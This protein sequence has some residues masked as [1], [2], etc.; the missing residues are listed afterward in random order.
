MTQVAD[1]R[2]PADLPVLRALLAEY[3]NWL[4]ERA[5]AV[6]GEEVD[7]GRLIEFAVSEVEHFQPPA[8]RMLLVRHGDEPAGLACMRGAGHGTAE[9]R[10]VFVRPAFRRAGLARRMVEDLAET[11]RAAGYD[12][13][14]LDTPAF[15]T[16]AQALYEASGFRKFAPD[17]AA[18]TK[19]FFGGTLV[20]ME[21]RLHST[22]EPTHPS[23]TP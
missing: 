21:R 2:I 16:Q 14:V 5:Q 22:S 15:L 9:I 11:A 23:A 19:P 12:R 13:I 7:V 3:L 17:P 1:A 8:G 20:F 10:R 6:S 4:A 18:H